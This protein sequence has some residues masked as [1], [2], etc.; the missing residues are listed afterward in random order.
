MPC[1][2]GGG[3]HRRMAYARVSSSGVSTK[4]GR[5]FPG[6]LTSGGYGKLPAGNGW[7]FCPTSGRNRDCNPVAEPVA[8]SVP[9]GRSTVRNDRSRRRSTLAEPSRHDKPRRGVASVWIEC[10][11]FDRCFSGRNRVTWLRA[12]A[13]S[14]AGG[15]SRQG[16]A[17]R[18]ELQ[19]RHGRRLGKG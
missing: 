9:G 3:G 16:V 1:P 13:H 17:R 11:S 12:A 15:G 14:D 18:L 19:P 4:S 5:F 6:F 7:W 10:A 2:Q 8:E